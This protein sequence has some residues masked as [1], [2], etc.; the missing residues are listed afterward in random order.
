MQQTRPANFLCMVLRV[1]EPLVRR[2]D[3]LINA[4]FFPF[5]VFIVAGFFLK[6]AENSVEHQGL[7][8]GIDDAGSPV[9]AV[10]LVH[11]DRELRDKFCEAPRWLR[12]VIIQG[13]LCLGIEEN[14]AA[15]HDVAEMVNTGILGVFL[16]IPPR[17]QMPRG[18]FVVD[19]GRHRM[20]PV[21]RPAVFPGSVAHGQSKMYQRHGRDVSNARLG[22]SETGLRVRINEFHLV[23]RY[24]DARAPR[25]QGGRGMGGMPAQGARQSSISSMFSSASPAASATRSSMASKLRSVPASQWAM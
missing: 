22:H 21:V 3:T 17:H 2:V 5:V 14:G 25:F 7:S 4:G 8:G 12:A 24:A 18:G 9:V 19:G 20:L 10:F 6:A 1:V 23:S 13:L 15:G 11:R 16:A